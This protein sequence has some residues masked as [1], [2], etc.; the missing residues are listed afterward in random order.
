VIEIKTGGNV[1]LYIADNLPQVSI[2]QADM[3]FEQSG[4]T[5][6]SIGWL[7]RGVN[8]I[9]WVQNQQGVLPG[10]HQPRHIALS[11]NLYFVAISDSA[12]GTLASNACQ[13]AFNGG[14]FAGSNKGLTLKN[15]EALVMNNTALTD[16]LEVYLGFS[17]LHLIQTNVNIRMNSDGTIG[18]LIIADQNGVSNGKRLETV[19]LA[20]GTVTKANTS[21]TA[22]SVLFIANPALSGALLSPSYSYT[23]SAGVGYTITSSDVADTSTLK[24]F[25]VENG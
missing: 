11:N 18:K 13:I 4:G 6:G 1:R 10:F 21:I 8:D 17:S 15:T 23:I 25:V 19:T 16:Y 2:I 9:G 3:F 22:N 14:T 7:D 24:V 5:P 20:A 12:A